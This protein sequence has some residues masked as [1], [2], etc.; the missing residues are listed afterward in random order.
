M[1]ASPEGELLALIINMAAGRMKLVNGRKGQGTGGGSL[2]LGALDSAAPAT[3]HNNDSLLAAG[4]SI[5]PSLTPPPS[6]LHGGWGGGGGGGGGVGGHCAGAS[7][8]AVRL[9]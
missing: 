7:P 5:T 1:P 6:T 3:G 4:H 2:A 9:D 8:A